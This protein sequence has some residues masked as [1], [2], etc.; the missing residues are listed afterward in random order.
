MEGIT[1]A[2]DLMGGDFG[3]RMSVPAIK[4]A[5]TFYS[6]LNII[7]YG[8]EHEVIGLLRSENLTDN[9]RVEFINAA[10]V[11]YNDENPI[12]AL[13]HKRQSSLWKAIE[14]VSNHKAM[15]AV[16]AGNTG[17]MVAIANHLLGNISGIHRS[18]LVKVLPSLNKNGTVFLD[19]GA[20]LHCD[21]E[22]L[23][24]FAIMGSVLASEHL[25]IDNLRVAILNVGRENCK[26]SEV[27]QKASELL[28]Q[29]KGINY[30]GYAEGN[31]IFSDYADVV[32]TD[33]FSGNIALKT[34]EGLYRVIEKKIYGNS[35]LLHKILIPLK[36]IVKSRITHMQ[37][38]GFNGSSLI[39]LNGVVV[40]SHGAADTSALVNAMAQ[41]YRECKNQMPRQIADGLVNLKGA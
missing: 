34:A 8:R 14:A 5:L 1:V 2:L 17:A 4:Q 19:L 9:S 25:K 21:Q 37:P 18:A 12:S 27:L 31:D 22:V 30:I 36:N 13:R 15:G 32:V 29:Y 26:G 7:A 10:D 38:D 16:S 20:N 40:K 24:Q 33:G 3:P 23:C 35:S 11:V 39:G 28:R 6:D 41:A